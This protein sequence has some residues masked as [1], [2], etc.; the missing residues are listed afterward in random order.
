MEQAQDSG[1]DADDARG[2]GR[3]IW[4]YCLYLFYDLASYGR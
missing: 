1:G 2:A 3:I 4:E